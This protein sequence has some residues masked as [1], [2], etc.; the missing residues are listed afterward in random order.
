MVTV[1][2]DLRY[3]ARTLARM[4]GMAIVA[5]LTLA[6]GIAATTTMFGVV[7][8]MLL[9]PLPFRDPDRLVILG[10]QAR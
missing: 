10:T 4:R 9:R 5:N 3:A 6:F 2:Q 8:A 1:F 7:Y